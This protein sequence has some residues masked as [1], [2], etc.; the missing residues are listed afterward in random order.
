MWLMLQQDKPDDYVVATGPGAIGARHVPGRVRP[1]RPRHG[2][3]CRRSIRRC[4]GRPRSTFC[5]A[6]PPRPNSSSAGSRPPVRGHDLR[7]GRCRPSTVGGASSPAENCP[8]A[9]S[10]HAFA[11]ADA[12]AAL[13]GPQPYTDSASR[14][15][16]M[17]SAATAGVRATRR[18]AASAARSDVASVQSAA[19]RDGRRGSPL[20]GPRPARCSICS[21]RR[22]GPSSWR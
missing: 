18:A 22:S 11:I 9:T 3:A 19:W 10:Q 1:C 6:T 12:V 4:S 2:R 5:T 16:R 21:P 8:L 15:Q 13:E 20:P 14:R 17:D 7:D